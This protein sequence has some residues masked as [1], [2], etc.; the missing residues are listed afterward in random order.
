MEWLGGGKERGLVDRE[1]REEELYILVSG[2]GEFE[3]E[4]EV[5]GVGEGRVVGVGGEGK[6]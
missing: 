4:G 2:K 1:E 5:L 6:G 3:V